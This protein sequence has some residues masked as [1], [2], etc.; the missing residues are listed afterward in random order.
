MNILFIFVDGLGVGKN[1]P[2]SNPC[3]DPRLQ[4]FN[5]FTDCERST[6]LPSD[7]SMCFIDAT[8]NTPGLPQSATGQ[9][10]LLT[11]INPA[12]ILGKH[13]SGFPNQK[14]RAIIS[15]HSLL[16]R[17]SRRNISA[18][19]INAYRPIFF[20]YGPEALLRYLSVTSIANWKAGLRFFSFDDLRQQRCIY[21]DF[22]NEDIIRKGFSV[23]RFSAAHA[24]RILANAAA[25]Y[26]FC[27]YEYFK[28][29]RAGHKQELQPAADLLFQLEQFVLS[30]LEHTD[31][32]R[33]LL[34]VT[35]DHGNIEDLSIKT[36][37]RNPVPLFAWGWNAENLTDQVRTIQ[38][39]TP[40]L[41]K[42]LINKYELT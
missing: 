7:G 4:I 20:E 18:A 26:R 34:F 31:L 33:T 36:H 8:L 32:T 41:N 17:C 40:I 42:F 38:Q 14:L 35:S 2:N 13:L 3:T 10:A 15:E 5:N 11:G 27:L 19:F 28:T 6:P 1:D 39:L 29:D 9:T 24:G 21:H 25:N 12:E 16:T 22:T 23:P 30:T 37:T